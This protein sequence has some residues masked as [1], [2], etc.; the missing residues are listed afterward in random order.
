N[1]IVMVFA[2][3]D[4]TANTIGWL[5]YLLANAPAAQARLAAEADAVLGDEPLGAD[6]TQLGRMPYLDACIQE[7]M[8]LKP[9]APILGA[10]AVVDAPLD[11]VPVPAGVVVF[12][13]LRHAFECDVPMADAAQFRPERWLEQ[14]FREALADPGRKLLPFGGGPRFCPGRYLAM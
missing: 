9:A 7:G 12:L 14:E 13:L 5:L 2:G 8:R 10:E 1:A 6:P 11:G 3:E 4:T